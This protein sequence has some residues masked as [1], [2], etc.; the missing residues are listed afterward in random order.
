MF[1]EGVSI[2]LNI[3]I[4]LLDINTRGRSQQYLFN[5]LLLNNDQHQITLYGKAVDILYQSYHNNLGPLI[6][7]LETYPVRLSTDF[8]FDTG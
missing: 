5:D 7:L 6:K 1:S 2:Y 8:P 4:V 3:N